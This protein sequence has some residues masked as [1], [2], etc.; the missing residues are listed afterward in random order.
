M[1]KGLVALLVL[2]AAACGG[3]YVYRGRAAASKPKTRLVQTSDVRT[4][5]LACVHCGRA[6][7]LSEASPLPGRPALADCPHCHKPTTLSPKR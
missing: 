5:T 6:F 2:A 7:R 4:Q 3:F 1:S